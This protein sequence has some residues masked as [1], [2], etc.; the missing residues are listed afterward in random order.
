MIKLLIKI[1]FNIFFDKEKLHD[2]FYKRNILYSEIS[3]K[4]IYLLP[5]FKK[6][7][8]DFN[9][10]SKFFYNQWNKVYQNELIEFILPLENIESIQKLIFIK[11]IY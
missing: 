11:T 4:E 5:V 8:K 1:K 2:L 9:L 3:D 6:K 10:Q 7:R